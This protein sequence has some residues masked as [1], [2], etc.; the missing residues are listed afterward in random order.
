M[1][2]MG[3]LSRTGKKK[4]N[5]KAQHPKGEGDKKTF[6]RQDRADHE[7]RAHFFQPVSQTFFSHIH[8]TPKVAISGG[9]VES[10][11]P[12]AT[13]PNRH[14]VRG[15]SLAPPQKVFDTPSFLFVPDG[16]GVFIWV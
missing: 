12:A 8:L 2:I 11:C 16:K 6:V 4:R 1:L 7:G 5:G 9:L 14:S 15:V 13:L 3:I 10:F